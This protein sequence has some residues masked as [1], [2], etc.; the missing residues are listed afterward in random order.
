MCGKGEDRAWQRGGMR[1]EREGACMAKGRRHAWQRGTCVAKGAMCVEGG[2]AWLQRQP[3]QW[4]VCILLECILV[5]H[6]FTSRLSK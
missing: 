1:G 5:L 3:L 2:H 6:F 4:A